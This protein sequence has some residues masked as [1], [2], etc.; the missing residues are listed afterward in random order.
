MQ[1]GIAARNIE[2]GDNSP[3]SI[4]CAP[5]IRK[6][7]YIQVGVVARNIEFGNNLPTL[8]LRAP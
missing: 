2:F 5:Q 8:I 6:F 1:V 3:T 7:E 4:L